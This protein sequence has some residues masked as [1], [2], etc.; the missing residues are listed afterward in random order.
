MLRSHND[1]VHTPTH[2]QYTQQY[3]APDLSG[4]RSW[5]C[6][7]LWICVRAPSLFSCDSFIAMVAVSITWREVQK[8]EPE[9]FTV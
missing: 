8:C 2:S 1:R 4:G 9:Q 6:V 7:W 3:H 5:P